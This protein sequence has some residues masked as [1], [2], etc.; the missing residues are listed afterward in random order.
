VPSRP[1]AHRFIDGDTRL[2]YRFEVAISAV[3][4]DAATAERIAERLE[5]RFP[6]AVLRGWQE[7]DAGGS[8]D[9]H[10]VAHALAHDARVVVVLHQRLWGTTAPTHADAVVLARRAAGEGTGFLHVVALEE[11]QPL[12]WMPGREEW[13]DFD[14]RGIDGVVERVI[15]VVAAGGGSARAVPAGERDARAEREART[16]DERD[17]FLRSAKALGGSKREFDAVI[18]EIE[19]RLS[20][21]AEVTPEFAFEVWRTPDRCIAQ[22]GD[23]GL[24]LSW[25]HSRSNQVADA[26]L[27]VMEW[28][29]VV[30]RPGSSRN[31]R[32]RAS[33]L[34]EQSLRLEASSPTSWRWRTGSSGGRSYSSTDLAAQYV[35]LLLQRSGDLSR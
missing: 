9:S 14:E 16:H 27:L 22:V 13:S 12:D 23:A 3:E 35:A 26:T 10:A 11:A 4:Y 21:V 17:T 15:E 32:R 33:V 6:L 29:G 31:D 34:R 1:S 8:D 19:R 2:A 24:S 7:R 28:E 25:M 18:A 5:D 30:T 20:E